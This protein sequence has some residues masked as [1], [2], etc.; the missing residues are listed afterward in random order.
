MYKTNI[1]LL[2]STAFGR[3]FPRG[4]QIIEVL[5]HSIFWISKTVTL[6]CEGVFLLGGGCGDGEVILSFELISFNSV[7]GFSSSLACVLSTQ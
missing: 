1:S 2:I 5:L 7:S 6:T 3:Q 4:S